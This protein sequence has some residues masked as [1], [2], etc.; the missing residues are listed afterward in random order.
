MQLNIIGHSLWTARWYSGQSR[1]DS[2]LERKIEESTIN[3]HIFKNVVR[4]CALE[5]S[6]KITLT[7]SFGP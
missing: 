6:S 5:L 1:I 7:I 2:E 4:Q 3:S